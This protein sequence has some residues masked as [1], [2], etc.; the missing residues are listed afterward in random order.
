[1]TVYLLV[2]STE[3][4]N[5]MVGSADSCRSRAMAYSGLSVPEQTSLYSF[6]LLGSAY[7][8]IPGDYRLAST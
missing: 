3:A 7:L 2:A 5:T 1:M 8:H 4:A 6:K